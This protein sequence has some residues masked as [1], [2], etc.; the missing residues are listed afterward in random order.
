VILSILY[1]GK[2]CGKAWDKLILFAD[3]RGRKKKGGKKRESEVRMAKRN[4]CEERGESV[5][6]T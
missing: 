2:A 5:F 3:K 4:P 1:C 6:K